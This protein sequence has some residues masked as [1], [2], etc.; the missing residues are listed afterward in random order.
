MIA[1]Q[2]Q[3]RLAPESRLG[4]H[5]ANCQDRRPLKIQIPVMPLKRDGLPSSPGQSRSAAAI[6]RTLDEAGADRAKRSELLAHIQDI[7]RVD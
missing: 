7:L 3:D 6:G 4:Q 2:G 1:H 5:L